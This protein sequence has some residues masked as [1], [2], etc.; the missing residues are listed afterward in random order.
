MK[1]SWMA[2]GAASTVE[3][4]TGPG[5]EAIR[6]AP[7]GDAGWRLCPEKLDRQPLFFAFPVPVAL[8]ADAIDV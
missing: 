8:E 2:P 1:A 7:C 3:D 6:A 5:W 4:S